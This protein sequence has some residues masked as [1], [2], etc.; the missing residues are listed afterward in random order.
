MRSG[1]VTE[2][3]KGQMPIQNSVLSE[4]CQKNFLLLGKFWSKN[5]NLEAETST[6]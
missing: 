6:L 3:A 4:N 5:A 1:I 2:R